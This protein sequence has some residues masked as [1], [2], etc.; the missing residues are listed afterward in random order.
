MPGLLALDLAPGRGRRTSAG[1]LAFTAA[2]RVIHRIHRHTA[3]LGA[4]AQ[5]SALARL[6]YRGETAP[7]DQAHL[8]GAEPEGDVVAF[9]GHHLSARARGARQL[10]ALADLEL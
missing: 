4:L 3:N 9:L 5:P 7:V 1:A 10:A 2:E 8:G 6:A